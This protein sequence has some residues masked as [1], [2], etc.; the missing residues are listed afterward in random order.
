MSESFTPGP[1]LIVRYGDSDSLVIHAGESDWRVCFMATPGSS[2]RSMDQIS[3][4][5]RL[6]ASAPELYEALKAI[7]DARTIPSAEMYEAA[8]AALAK[9]KVQSE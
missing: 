6:I 1:W 3:A 8:R 5:A 9:A 2:P 4:N 7:V